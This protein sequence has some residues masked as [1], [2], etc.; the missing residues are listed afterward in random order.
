MPLLSLK[1]V[2]MWFAAFIFLTSLN[3]AH[4]ALIPAIMEE[5][6]CFESYQSRKRK[7][8]IEDEVRPLMKNMFNFVRAPQFPLGPSCNRWEKLTY[9]ENRLY[10]KKLTHM[11]SWEIF[12]LHE[13][14]KEAIEKPRGTWWR[15]KKEKSI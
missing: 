6:L 15:K 11:Y 10:C 4:A 1:D 14:C 7:R 8:E 13:L 9:D 12:Q 3:A 2:A 5:D